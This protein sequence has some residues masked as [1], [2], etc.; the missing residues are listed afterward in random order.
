MLYHC[1]AIA[2]S[3]TSFVIS[4]TSPKVMTCFVLI[5]LLSSRSFVFRSQEILTQKRKNRGFTRAAGFYL[6]DRCMYPISIVLDSLRNDV[7]R[8]HT[9]IEAGAP[10]IDELVTIVQP[11]SIS[12][13]PMPTCTNATP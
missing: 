3:S 9:T 13:T 2:H 11:R 10:R 6:M 8:F 5:A 7:R 12:G 4:A 1:Q